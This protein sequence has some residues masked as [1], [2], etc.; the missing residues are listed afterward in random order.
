M[1]ILTSIAYIQASSCIF[2]QMRTFL[3]LLCLHLNFLLSAWAVQSRHMV[4]FRMISPIFLRF[5][6]LGF[7]HS[8]FLVITHLS[9]QYA[10]GTR[11]LRAASPLRSKRLCWLVLTMIASE[12]SPLKQQAWQDCR[13]SSL[14]GV[15]KAGLFIMH[16]LLLTIP[17]THVMCVLGLMVSRLEWAVRAGS[18]L[19]LCGLFLSRICRWIG[20]SFFFLLLAE[21]VCVSRPL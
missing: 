4:S 19:V 20:S 10:T 13:A 7:C 6:W 12:M 15:H 2:E 21:D 9:S 3:C 8:D 17:L 1:Y 18:H 16:P 5:Q 11:A 14:R